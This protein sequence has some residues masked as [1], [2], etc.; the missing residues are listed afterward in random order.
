MGKGNW[1]SNFFNNRLES[2]EKLN[3]AYRRKWNN[4]DW[5]YTDLSKS[6]ELSPND[7]WSK[8]LRL[9]NDKATC[10]Y[11]P[12]RPYYSSPNEYDSANWHDVNFTK[13]EVEAELL[14]VF[15]KY[16][17]Y[18]AHTDEGIKNDVLFQSVLA[19]LGFMQDVGA[20]YGVLRVGHSI[21]D[22][23][24]E[25]YIMKDKD[26]NRQIMNHVLEKYDDVFSKLYDI[27][28]IDKDI[29]D[30]LNLEDKDEMKR[31][32]KALTLSH[33]KTIFEKDNESIEELRDAAISCVRTFGNNNK[34]FIR[35]ANIVG[36]DSKTSTERL[37]D[38]YKGY[39]KMFDK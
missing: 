4:I 31:K 2:I 37:L 10:G 38:R 36:T 35:L 16:P 7:K 28:N 24:I 13:D 6:D 3:L 14:N 23:V 30:I 17:K 33:C 39:L 21:S 11:Y 34:D 32:L 18:S 5:M 26:T 8:A 9:L 22:D 12:Y 29:D 25:T 1:W 27:K 15:K 19:M 20:Y